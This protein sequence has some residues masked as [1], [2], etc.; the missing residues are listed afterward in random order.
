MK[1]LLPI[2][3]RP[4]IFQPIMSYLNSLLRTRTWA[5]AGGG[6]DVGLG[7][8]HFHCTSGAP[9]GAPVKKNSPVYFSE[10]ATAQKSCKISI[11]LT[12]QHC[13]YSCYKDNRPKRSNRCKKLKLCIKICPISWIAGGMFSLLI[14]HSIKNH[15]LVHH[16]I[17]F[18]EHKASL[19]PGYTL[20]CIKMYHFPQILIHRWNDFAPVKQ[21]STYTGVSLV[22]RTGN[23]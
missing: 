15:A 17:W 23:T 2:R 7:I 20:F 9:C 21:W 6:P 16:I 19:P 14:T 3:I 5:R 1:E 4:M 13:G 22:H 12:L 11:E 18:V 10:T 8:G